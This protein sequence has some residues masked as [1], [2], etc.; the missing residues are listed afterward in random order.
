[1]LSWFVGDGPIMANYLENRFPFSSFE[2]DEAVMGNYLVYSFINT[3][4][5]SEQIPHFSRSR[6]R[7][8]ND[9]PLE[10]NT[11]H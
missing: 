9:N 11:P 4:T 2:G 6:V 5:Y 8:P 7:P 10:K 1:M 3:M